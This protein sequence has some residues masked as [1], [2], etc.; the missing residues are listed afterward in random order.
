MSTRTSVIRRTQDMQDSVEEACN[1]CRL[2]SLA[3]ATT[4]AKSME[5]IEWLI[6]GTGLKFALLNLIELITSAKFA[7]SFPVFPALWLTV[8]GL[9]SWRPAFLRPYKIW[10]KALRC[11]S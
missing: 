8:W 5:P 6:V 4:L 2:A 11:R 3:L 7:C 1:V 10:P 9:K